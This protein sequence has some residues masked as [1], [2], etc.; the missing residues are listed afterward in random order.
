MY[1]ILNKVQQT[2]PL[3]RLLDIDDTDSY[4]PET[5]TIYNLYTGEY[6]YYIYNYSGSPEITTSGAVVQIFNDNGS[7]SQPYKYLLLAQGAIGIYVQ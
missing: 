1:I 3:M 7:N 2:V 5:T 4:G 6:H